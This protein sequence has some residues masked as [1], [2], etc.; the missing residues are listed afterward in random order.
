MNYSIVQ[1]EVASSSK[2]GFTR[3][4]NFSTAEAIS[5]NE[6]FKDLLA[7]IP[8]FLQMFF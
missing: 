6:V 1:K 5:T 3:R 8:L 7:E 2:Y 4:T